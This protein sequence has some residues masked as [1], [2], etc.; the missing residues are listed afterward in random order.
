[1]SDA[2]DATRTALQIY[3][4]HKQNGLKCCWCGDKWPCDAYQM[5]DAYRITKQDTCPE[6]NDD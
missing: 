5:W 3:A 4:F 2:A 1:M 6:A